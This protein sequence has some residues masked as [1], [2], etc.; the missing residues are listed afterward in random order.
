L[1]LIQVGKVAKGTIDIV[2]TPT[3]PISV[4]DVEDESAGK[5]S[6]VTIAKPDTIRNG[7]RLVYTI[8]PEHRGN[9]SHYIRVTLNYKTSYI[10]LRI[11]VIGMA[12]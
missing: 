12:I 4:E 3:A 2:G 8:C 11:P 9:F 7:V 10:K 1:G 5:Q 6:V